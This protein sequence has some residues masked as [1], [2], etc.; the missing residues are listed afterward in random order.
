M[1]S[2]IIKDEE[3]QMFCLEGTECCFYTE[4]LA[5]EYA[6]KI[7]NITDENEKLIIFK[8]MKEIEK[9][10][11]ASLDEKVANEEIQIDEPMSQNIESEALEQPAAEHKAACGL[12]QEEIQKSIYDTKEPS[13]GLERK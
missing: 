5:I 4:E 1:K 8:R 13:V 11:R 3:T 6:E 7:E 10:R 9:E 12:S 2:N